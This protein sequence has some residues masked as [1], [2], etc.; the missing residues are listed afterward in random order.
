MK[1]ISEQTVRPNTG[2]YA[3]VSKGQIVRIAAKSVVDGRG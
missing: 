3:E 2:W 1:T